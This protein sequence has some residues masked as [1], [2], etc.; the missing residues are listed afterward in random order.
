[1][2]KLNNIKL[3]WKQREEVG[4]LEEL[5]YH[6]PDYLLDLLYELVWLRGLKERRT[7]GVEK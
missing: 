3:D 1:M 4:K 5:A 2:G 6:D 7:G